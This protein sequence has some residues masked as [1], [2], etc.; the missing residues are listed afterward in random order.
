MR[1]RL[2]LVLALA[3][4]AATTAFAHC[5][6]LDGPVVKAARKALESGDV[7]L[8]LPWVQPNDE[9]VIRQ[10]FAR[11]L[12]VRKL[13]PEA[14]QLADTWFF[15]T[16]VRIH[17]AGEGAPFEG[18]KP[19]GSDLGPAVS[20]ADKAIETGS[21]E[22]L[23]KMLTAAAQEGLHQRFHLVLEARQYNP[24]DVKAGREYV[25]AYVEFIHFAERVH[26]ALS[27]GTGHTAGHE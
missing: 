11:T 6:T 24:S 22:P 14:Q 21:I 3:F 26:Q 17:R 18:L 1:H 2:I 25:A 10:A 23:V 27:A 12:I 7:N 16:L 9:A 5:D 13:N 15:E 19:A 20:A 4:W 8:I